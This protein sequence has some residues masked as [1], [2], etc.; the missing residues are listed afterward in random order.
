MQ[1]HSSVGRPA[2]GKY[3][4]DGRIGKTGCK[5]APISVL[6]SQPAGYDINPGT[7]SGEQPVQASI[8]APDGTRI[9]KD[10][11]DSYSFEV[12]GTEGV[13]WEISMSDGTAS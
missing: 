11:F 1:S 5:D 4:H 2:S 7:L 10:T 6:F 13:N 9:N 12:T 3:Q 8:S